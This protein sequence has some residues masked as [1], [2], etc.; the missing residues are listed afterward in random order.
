[1][2]GECDVLVVGAGPAGLM[3]AVTA[4][5]AGARV[6]V[7]DRREGP[8]D[9][10]RAA[11]VH[12]RTLETWHDVGLADAA[13]A[14]GIPVRHV[15]VSVAGRRLTSFGLTGDGRE[16]GAFDHALALP[17]SSTERM[18]GQAL[19]GHGVEVEWG[20]RLTDLRQEPS[21]VAA[22][23]RVG[24]QER[25][26]HASYVVG[27]DGAHSTVR[28]LSGIR[29]EGDSYAPTAFLADVGL[30]VAPADD[31]LHLNL[32]QGGFVGIQHLGDGWY[33][34]FGALSPAYAARFSQLGPGRPI[35]VADVQRWFDEYFGIRARITDV[36]WTSV[37]RL[38]HRLAEEFVDG[39]VA[40]VGD[41]AHL[42]APAGGQG[43]NL[44]IGDAAN[45]GWKL[46]ALATGQGRPRLLDSYQAE[47]RPVAEA[48]LRNADRGFAWEASDSRLLEI[49]RRTLLPAAVSAL[50]RTRAAQR[51]IFRL[52]SQTWITYH[53]Q[54]TVTH[55]LGDTRGVRAGDRLPTGLLDLGAPEDGSPAGLRHHLLVI[56]PDDDR[57]ADLQRRYR[58]ILDAVAVP[59]D[60]RLVDPDSEPG[61]RLVDGGAARAILVRP[62][63]HAGHV[64]DVDDVDGLATHLARWY[65]A[66][67]A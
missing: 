10:S 17:Q 53:G 37:Y 61:R 23:L 7:V 39:R 66:R 47:R 34:L 11:I 2:S 29:F 21:G 62:D 49:L 26:I 55:N 67:S 18:L 60:V 63:R 46:A 27:A 41:A 9:Q 19:R 52:F 22:I 35:P 14:E 15:T 50:A 28:E 57:S 48:V 54:P 1:M 4:A 13:L 30:S 45:L 58:R 31:G 24:D 43:M 8:T 6:R 44:G 16:A 59:V 38:H 36:G 42:H 33:R 25:E 5:R 12:V 56:A 51:V 65:T 32:A 3:T 40:L 20:S 64:G